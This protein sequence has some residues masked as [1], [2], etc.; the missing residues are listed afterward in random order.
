MKNVLDINAEL[1]QTQA[2]AT[3]ANNVTHRKYF[4]GKD[5]EN[6]EKFYEMLCDIMHITYEAAGYYLQSLLVQWLRANV[7]NLSTHTHT[8][9]GLRST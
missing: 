1:C 6:C 4:T 3:A 7:E 8:Q 5:D 2:T 9:V